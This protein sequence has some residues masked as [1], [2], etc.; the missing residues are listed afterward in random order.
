MTLKPIGKILT[1]MLLWLSVLAAAGCDVSMPT[2][3]SSG[4]SGEVRTEKLKTNL[5]AEEARALAK[6]ASSADGLTVDVQNAQNMGV[7]SE[8]FGG[9]M[10]PSRGLNTQRL[11]SERVGDSDERFERLENAVQQLR[12]DF[13]TV[14]P[15]I[16]RL[17]AIE[18]EIQMLVDQLQVLVKGDNAAAMEQIPPVSAQALNETEFPV[19]ENPAPAAPIPLAP[20]L[21]QADVEAA[22]EAPAPAAPAP[23]AAHDSAPAATIAA[24][25]PAP[26]PAASVAATSGASLIALRVAD[27]EK[28]TRV[29]FETNAKIAYSVDVDP[30]KIL[31]VTF[32][33]GTS[34]ANLSAS[35]KSSLIKSADETP[36]AAGGFIVAMPLSKMTKIVRQG[37]L[38]PDGANPRFRIYIDLER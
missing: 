36:Q 25:Q 15:A 5:S 7:G 4:R 19:E 9:I 11:F 34:Q 8:N 20:P 28:T 27:H 6:P 14:N 13:D 18:G 24:P 1:G 22:V 29:V 33:E 16:N 12:D 21:T 31:L 17:I 26:A 23:D 38:P 2:P 30:E 37:V 32:K 10:Q 35:L 3:S